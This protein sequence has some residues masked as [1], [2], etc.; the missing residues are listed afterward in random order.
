[1]SAE[2]DRLEATL[3]QILNAFVPPALID[4]VGPRGELIAVALSEADSAAKVWPPGR[5]LPA[6]AP[7][8][9]HTTNNAPIHAFTD[10]L[11]RL[12]EELDGVETRND[13]KVK[14]RRKDVVRMAV[15]EL[16]VTDEWIKRILSIYK[17]GLDGNRAV[18]GVSSCSFSCVCSSCCRRA[19][20]WRQR[21]ASLQG[22]IQLRCI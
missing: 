1:M 17:Y 6:D 10:R 18:G 5:A 9:P 12:L 15:D 3:S 4:V 11:S 2:V 13:D 8:L 7:T 20:L 14:I 22:I 21:A 16:D 19:R